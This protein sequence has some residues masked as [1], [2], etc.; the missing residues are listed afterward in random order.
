MICL[1]DRLTIFRLAGLARSK[2]K[3]DIGKQKAKRMYGLLFTSRLRYLY[4]Y[5]KDLRCYNESVNRQSYVRL[6]KPS[7]FFNSDKYKY[8]ES[9]LFI[10]IQYK[11]YVWTEYMLT[12]ISIN[13]YPIISGIKYTRIQMGPAAITYINLIY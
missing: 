2:N 12:C 1:D 7:S 10:C 8:F 6:Q 4:V 5:G 13:I 3:D 11:Y 9:H